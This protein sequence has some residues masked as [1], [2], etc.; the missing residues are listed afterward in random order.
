[1]DSPDWTTVTYSMKNQKNTKNQERGSPSCVASCLPCLFSD[2]PNATPRHESHI[3]GTNK[4]GGQV[5]S[6]V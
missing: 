6:R 2:I 5:G 4:V 1:M 3:A